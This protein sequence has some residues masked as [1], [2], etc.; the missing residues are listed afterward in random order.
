MMQACHV[1]DTMPTLKGVGWG[2]SP[3]TGLVGVRLIINVEACSSFASTWFS[4]HSHLAKFRLE[5]SS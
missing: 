1:R 5:G 4:V 3:Q 2:A